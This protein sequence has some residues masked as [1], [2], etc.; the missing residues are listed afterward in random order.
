MKALK[1]N[2]SVRKFALARVASSVKAGAGASVGPLE[3]QLDANEPPQ[4]TVARRPISNRSFRFRS[5]LVTKLLPIPTT[6]DEWFSNPFWVA[7]RVTSH[8]RVL[9]ARPEI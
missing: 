7:R 1:I 2:R 6:A 4:L 9:S 5:Y 8:Q 3:L